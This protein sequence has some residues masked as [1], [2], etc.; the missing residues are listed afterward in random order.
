MKNKINEI[1]KLP[2]VFNYLEFVEFKK[3]KNKDKVKYFVS[4]KK[5]KTDFVEFCKP[6]KKLVRFI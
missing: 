4:N 2:H 5:Y 3:N 6:E 1:N